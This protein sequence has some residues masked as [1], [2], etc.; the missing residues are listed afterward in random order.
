[1]KKEIKI[2]DEQMW[3]EKRKKYITATEMMFAVTNFC[4]DEDFKAMNAEFATF[5]PTKY[6]FYCLKTMNNEQLKLWNAYLNEKNKNRQRKL[7]FGTNNELLVAEQGLK[8]LMEKDESFKDAKLVA[9]GKNLWVDGNIAST[10]DFFIEKPNGDKVLLE[11]KTRER[12]D[13]DDELEKTL[14]KYELQVKTQ[15]LTT[16]IKEAYIAMGFHENFEIKEVKTF[17]IEVDEAM[18][19]LEFDC[20]VQ[21]ANSCIEWINNVDKSEESNCFDNQNDDDIAMKN[22]VEKS[23]KEIAEK[24]FENNEL[25]TKYHELLKNKEINEDLLNATFKMIA[26]EN[27]TIDDISVDVK[28]TKTSYYEIDKINEQIEKLQDIK[29]KLENGEQVISRNGSLSIQRVYKNGFNG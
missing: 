22:I 3:L 23:L 19:Q 26:N 15:M 27:I 24:Y 11:C 2:K 25:L 5:L 28:R 7:D 21:S 18:L 1:M 12:K 17:K 29:R 13:N 6:Q 16:G 10:P 8:H 20:M 9:N 4:N 14:K